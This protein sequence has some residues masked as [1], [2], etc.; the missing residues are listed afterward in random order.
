VRAWAL[1]HGADPELRIIVCGYAE[2]HAELLSHGWKA[3]RWK[4]ARGYAGEDN[5]NREQETLFLSP[6]CLPVEQQ[7]SLFEGVA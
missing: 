4:G 3:H 7:R 6:H 2:E 1:E 5:D